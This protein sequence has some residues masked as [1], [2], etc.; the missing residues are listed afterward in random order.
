[1]TI[2]V[3]LTVLLLGVAVW[4]AV[5]RSA[6]RLIQVLVLIIIALGAYFV[7]APDKA[8]E[9]AHA[10]GVGR[11]ADL[12]FYVWVVITLALILFMYLKIQRLTRRVTQLTRAMAL[13]HPQVPSADGEPQ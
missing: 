9:L 6:S 5:Q 2:Q 13:Q 11:G 4:V 3:F 1:M 7:W 8:N 10:V 12:L